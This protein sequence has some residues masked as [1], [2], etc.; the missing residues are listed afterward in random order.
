LLKLEELSSIKISFMKKLYLST[1]ILMASRFV[2]AQKHEFG[3]GYQLSLPRQMMEKGWN[4]GH[5]LNMDY[6]FHP[7]TVKGF[8]IGTHLGYGSYASQSQP[9]EYRFIDGTITY[10]NVNLSSSIASGSLS[11]RYAPLISKKFSPFAEIQ[12][13]YLG[14]FS[15]LYIEDP[16]DP[17]GCRP[18]ESN[19][20]V[21]SGSLFFALGGG[22]QLYLGQ[23][24][25][26]GKQKHLLELSAR[27]LWGGEMEY[28]NM[29]RLYNHAEVTGNPMPDPEMGETPLMVTFINASTSQQ[30]M[31][32]VAEL[33]NHPLRMVQIQ[34]QYVVRMN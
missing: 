4:N 28:A 12:G 3:I 32:T 26:D 22:I 24:K 16:R 7:K 13:G 18:L 10:T 11:A 2:F 15:D 14:M 8:S 31:H 9:Q 30:H 1:F 17:L 33:Y 19:T 29:N 34:L 23:G 27:T 20:L 21:S 6:F 5:G 25:K